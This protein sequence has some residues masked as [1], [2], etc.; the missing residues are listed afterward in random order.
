MLQVIICAALA[1]TL[2][3]NLFGKH[4]RMIDMLYG[5]PVNDT[6]FMQFT[7][8]LMIFFAVH[9]LTFMFLVA[10]LLLADIFGVIDWKKYNWVALNEKVEA[11]L[12]K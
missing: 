10:A 8:G 1:I 2:S 6:K 11:A 7:I 5:K 12:S 3:F 4:S 9:S